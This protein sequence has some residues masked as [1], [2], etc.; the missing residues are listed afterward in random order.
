MR[1][2]ASCALSRKDKLLKTRDKKIKSLKLEIR[3]RDELHRAATKELRE[4]VEGA[5]KA[6]REIPALPEIVGDAG[7]DPY[8]GKWFTAFRSLLEWCL[9]RRALTLLALVG[10]L[11]FSIA[12]LG[13]LFVPRTARCPRG[14]RYT[15]A[16]G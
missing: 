14:P 8:G 16:P 4:E 3:K 2:G 1:A 5:R 12:N 13:R 9:R 15:C 7:A 11:L 6:V 10:V